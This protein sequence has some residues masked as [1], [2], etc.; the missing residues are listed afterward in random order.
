MQ[1]EQSQ[2]GSGELW[3]ELN[4]CVE[5]SLG[6]PW[7]LVLHLGYAKVVVRCCQAWDFLDYL[8]QGINS[9]GDFLFTERYSPS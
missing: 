2:V 4:G 7:L 6:N 3:P 1:L 9:L 8:L 5:G